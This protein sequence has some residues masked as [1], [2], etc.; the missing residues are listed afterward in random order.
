MLSLTGMV[1][2]I[3]W[4]YD[5]GPDTFFTAPHLVLYSG[6]AIAG[7][8]SLAVVLAT[9]MAERRGRPVDP[10][11]GGAAVGVF[12]RTFAAPIG[13]LV[14]GVG[15]ALFLVYGLLDEWWHGLYGFDAVIESPPHIGFLLAITLT[16]AG[17]VMVS[18]A[19]LDRRWGG[20]TAVIGLALLLGFGSI[21]VEGLTA[22]GV[23]VVDLRTAGMAFLSVLVLV[24]GARLTGRAAGAIG[25]SLILVAL[26]AAFWWF[27]PWATRVYA[28]AIAQP[29]RDVPSDVPVG[30]ALIPMILLPVAAVMGPVMARADDG[31]AVGSAMVTGGIGGLVVT[32]AVAG[33]SALLLGGDTLGELPVLVATAAVGTALGVAAGFL[34]VRFAEI[35]RSLT[36]AVEGR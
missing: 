14:S 4:H 27:C 6:S 17:A 20:I 32:V 25:I 11:V 2:D 1:W 21:V 3:Q 18:A 10:A 35:L 34:G 23:S 28:D 12:G 7:I 26:Q 31:R 24:V 16:M 13:Y 22:F 19:A 29:F 9:T 30:P 8:A 36:P 15:A 33:Q 5:V